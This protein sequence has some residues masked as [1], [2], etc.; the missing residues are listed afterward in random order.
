M[1]QRRNCGD[2]LTNRPVTVLPVELDIIGPQGNINGGVANPNGLD[3]DVA[4]DVPITNGRQVTAL[5]FCRPRRLNKLPVTHEIRGVNPIGVI[6]RWP[7]GGQT[8]RP[9]WD[10]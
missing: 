4:Q 6:R 5:I 9:V 1:R 7:R 8:Q 10:E 2:D 3:V